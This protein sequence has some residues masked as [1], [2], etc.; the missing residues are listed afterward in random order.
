VRMQSF[1]VEVPGEVIDSLRVPTAEAP[2][3]VKRELAVRLYQKG[4]LT[5]GKARALAEQSK[6]AFHELLAAEGIARRY[7]EADL[8]ADEQALGRLP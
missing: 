3:R 4:L 2:G 7:D 5:F 6:W 8:A 1:M